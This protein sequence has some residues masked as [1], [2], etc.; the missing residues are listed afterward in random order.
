MVS[1]VLLA[2]VIIYRSWKVH[3]E[4]EWQLKYAPAGPGRWIVKV[5][6]WQARCCLL[7]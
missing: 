4:G 7:K 1:Q 6:L 3:S 5:I 2:E